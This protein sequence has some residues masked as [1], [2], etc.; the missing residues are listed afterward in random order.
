M[1]VTDYIIDF[2]IEKGITDIFG[3]PGGVICHL[4]DSVLKRTGEISNHGTYHEQG[5]AFAACGY[6]QATGK[7]GVAYATSGPGAT[8]LV[9]GIANAY[10]D[11]IPTLFITGQV[12]TYISKAELPIRQRGFQETDVVAIMS[13]ISKWCINVDSPDKIRYCLEKAYWMLTEGN[14][15]PVVLDIP[16]DVQRAEVDVIMSFHKLK[17]LS[18]HYARQNVHVY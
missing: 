16:A 17:L 1:K 5:A 15:G 7:I 4:M 11:S 13:G 10:F 3:Y 18:V 8:N 9:T 6:A 12:D 14:P 2:L